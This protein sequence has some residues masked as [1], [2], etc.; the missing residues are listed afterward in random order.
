MP[1]PYRLASDPFAAELL[2]P[3]LRLPASA[4]RLAPWAAPAVHRALGSVLLGLNYHVSLRTRAIDDAVREG[5]KNG[6]T[7]LVVLG[8]GLDSRALRMDELRGVTAFE[9]DHPSTQA[10]K[11][12]RL[13]AAGNPQP[14]AKRLEHVAI[15][16]ET[17]VLADVM[18]RAGFDPDARSFWI[19]EGVTV[20]LT[21]DAIKETLRVVASL[22]APGSRIALTY[23]M[24]LGGWVGAAMPIAKRAFSLAGEPLKTPIE[25]G[26]MWT[27]LEREGFGRVSDEP[28]SGWAARYYPWQTHAARDIERLAVAE[29]RQDR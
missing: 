20:Y 25:E 21:P 14:R 6:A 10:Y 17:E 26:E 5:I 27:I 13:R 12:E 1:E 24:A 4:V 29:R 3:I 28:T 23:S 15:D 18:L 7:Q 22:S 2:S 19:W 11:L 9:V 8:A 16:F